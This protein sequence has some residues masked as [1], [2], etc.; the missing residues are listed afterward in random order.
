MDTGRRA[1]LRGSLLTQAGRVQETQ[2]QQALG[3]PPPWHGRLSLEAHCPDCTHPGVN[4]CEPGIIRRHPAEHTL[5]GIPWLDFSATGC[6][7]CA[8]CVDVCPIED[9][10]LD[11]RGSPPLI[12]VAQLNRETCLAWS[13]VICQSCLGRCTVQAITSQWQREVQ[14]DASLCNGCGMCISACPV[15]ALNIVRQANTR[16]SRP[17]HQHR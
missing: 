2:R 4:A 8:A 7:F 13:G 1:F 14:I 10:A 11:S 16:A 15:N 5:A 6:T 12:G 9:E 17:P 3:P